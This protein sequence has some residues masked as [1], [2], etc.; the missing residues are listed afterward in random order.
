MP[1]L[2]KK[3]IIINNKKGDKFN[4]IEN[5]LQNNLISLIIYMCMG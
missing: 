5:S 2:I 4:Q 3:I 1:N